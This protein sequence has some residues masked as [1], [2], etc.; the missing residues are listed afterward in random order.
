MIPQF[1]EPF[2]FDA[3]VV[4]QVINRAQNIPGGKVLATHTAVSRTLKDVAYW[5]AL[6]YVGSFDYMV[7]MSRKASKG[8]ELTPAQLAGVLNCLLAEARRRAPITPAVEPAP[9]RVGLADMR[10]VPAPTLAPIAAQAPAQT[11]LAPV[12]PTVRDGIYTL[13]LNQ[14]GDYRTL[15]IT[16]ATDEQREQFKLPQGAQFAKYL[17]GQDNEHSYT[18]FA[19]VI[20]NQVRIWSKFKADSKLVEALNVLVRADK[21][22]QSDYGQAYALESGKCWRCGRTLTVPASVNRGLGPDCAKLV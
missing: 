14:E 17:S 3:P 21:A 6:N 1:S 2:S 11:A 13:V 15:R 16:T 22:A 7:D 5:Y 19:F 8:I 9:A 20:G 4:Q 12:V 18:G 10:T